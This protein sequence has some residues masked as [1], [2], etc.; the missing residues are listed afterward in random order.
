MSCGEAVVVT[1]SGKVDDLDDP[2]IVIN[3]TEKPLKSTIP[4]PPHPTSAQPQAPPSPYSPH[5]HSH[6]ATAAR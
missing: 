1:E 5:S 6:A 3:P 2:R 4:I